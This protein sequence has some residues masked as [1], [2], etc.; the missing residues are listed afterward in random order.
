VEET[1]LGGDEC[2][3]G[4]LKGNAGDGELKGGREM[5]EGKLKGGRERERT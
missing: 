4:G 3:G 5:G 1:V 2:M